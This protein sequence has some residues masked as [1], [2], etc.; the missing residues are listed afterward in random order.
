MLTLA[1]FID[2]TDK[3][4]TRLTTT[5]GMQPHP[6][7]MSRCIQATT[8]TERMKTSHCWTSM[9]SQRLVLCSITKSTCNLFC[10]FVCDIVDY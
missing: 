10:L 5:A 3:T 1:G 7:L 9:V 8:L 4:V 2:L 6:R